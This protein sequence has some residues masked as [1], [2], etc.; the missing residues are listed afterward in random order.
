MRVRIAHR[1]REN[2]NPADLLAPRRT[3]IGGSN[4]PYIHT[5]LLNYQNY[6]LLLSLPVLVKDFIV[7]LARNHAQAGPQPQAQG[8]Q[9]IPGGGRARW[10]TTGAASEEETIQAAR[11]CEPVLR[12]PAEIVRWNLRCS[13][14]S[15]GA[16][17][18]EG[19][20]SR[21][22][23][24][25]RDTYINSP[26]SPDHMDWASHYPAFADPD[27]NNTNLGGTRRLLKDVEV[28]D[29]G[30]GFG[31]LLVAMAPL[32]PDTLMVGTFE[33]GYAPRLWLSRYPHRA[34]NGLQQAWNSDTRSLIT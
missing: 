34:K 1:H 6:S 22:L 18:I 24:A 29:I 4:T 12:S 25:D 11:A 19:G 15:P 33:P 20:E 27:S 31:G 26:I 7:R 14:R 16:F 13:S 23:L 17:L 32:M 8:A 2:K 30:C 28:A 5:T 10:R 3:A 21:C 9:G